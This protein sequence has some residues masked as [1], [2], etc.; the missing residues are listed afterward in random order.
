MKIGEEGMVGHVA[1]TGKMHYAPNVHRDPYY[2]P[3]EENAMSAVAIPLKIGDR[4]IGV[5]HAIHPELDGFSREQLHL[6]RG[7]AEHIAIAIENA[8]LFQRERESNERHDREAEEA[9]LI[10]R[11]LLPNSSLL[12]PGFSVSGASLPAGAVGGDWYDYLELGNGKWGIVLADVAGK[13]MAAALLMSATRGIFRAIAENVPSPGEVLARLN[14]SLLRDF[15]AGRFVT[16]IYGVLDPALRSFTFA[17]AGHPW[18]VIAK[19][20][21]TRLVETET[22][23]P[24]GIADT[25]FSESTVLLNEGARVLF[26]SDGISEAL[27]GEQQEYGTE[28]LGR[29]IGSPDVT[30]ES[31]LDD[32]GK[33]SAGVPAFD[34]ATVVLVSARR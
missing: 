20:T 28:R 9:G 32:V 15:P 6:L 22:G 31:I 11:Q 33:F 21:C 16:M 23:L 34:D 25:A 4:V 19:G 5:F 7:L 18:P 13:G 2:L 3:C 30:T 26:Y 14:R 24:L 1:F 17:N 27:N 12:L 29:L 10:Q 8:R